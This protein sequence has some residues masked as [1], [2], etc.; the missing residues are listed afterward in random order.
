VDTKKRL[1][2]MQLVNK[3]ASG[4]KEYWVYGLE[5]LGVYE[6]R[7]ILRFRP[8]TNDGGN[9]KHDGNSAK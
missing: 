4:G 1:A 8:T 3:R 5:Q 9:N 6:D 2:E 7:G